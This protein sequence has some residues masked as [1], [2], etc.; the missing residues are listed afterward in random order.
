MPVSTR[1]A[2]DSVERRPAIP[3]AMGNP[4]QL[5]PR[6]AIAAGVLF[7]ACGLWPIVVGAGVVHASEP[8]QSSWVAVAAGMIFVFGG[9]A[10]ILDYGIAGGVGPDGDLVAGTPFV[11]RAL[12]FVLGLGILGLMIAVFGWVAFGPGPRQFSTMIALPFV[13][14]YARS[15]ELSGRIAFGCSTLLLTLMF[16]ICGVTGVRKLMR[17]SRHEVPQKMPNATA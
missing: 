11:I 5:T 10:V 14:Y 6:G 4:N 8:P 9:L 12:N 16:I 3:R 13:S 7:I 17:T 1:G 2:P 15:G